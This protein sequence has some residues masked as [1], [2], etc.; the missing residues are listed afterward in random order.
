MSP[1]AILGTQV[2]QTVNNRKVPILQLTSTVMAFYCTAVALA[3]AA[4]RWCQ[5]VGAPSGRTGRAVRSF[6]RSDGCRQVSR[7]GDGEASVAT[8]LPVQTRYEP[9]SR[10]FFLCSPRDGSFYCFFFVSYGGHKMKRSWEPG[11]LRVG[12]TGLFESF[13]TGSK[14][15][16]R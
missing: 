9:S 12:G 10:L 6:H 3:V 11:A 2:Q 7:Q 13:P 8:R 1:A 4:G 14:L 15:C 16:S 5:T